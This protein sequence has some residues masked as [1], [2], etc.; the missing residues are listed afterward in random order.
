MLNSLIRDIIATC[1]D[2]NLLLRYMENICANE[3]IPLSAQL[4]LAEI[5][6]ERL[7]ELN[8]FKAAVSAPP[9]LCGQSNPVCWN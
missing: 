4:E 2:V 9:C 8:P 3:G 5:A 7:A 1:T 6:N